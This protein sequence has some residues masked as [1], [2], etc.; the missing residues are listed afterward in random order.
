MYLSQ[1][2]KYIKVV[3]MEANEKSTIKH[4]M[5]TSPCDFELDSTGNLYVVN[6]GNP[7]NVCLF[8]R[9]GNYIKTLF[10]QNQL[11]GIGLNSSGDKLVVTYEQFISVYEL[12]K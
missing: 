12:Q 11:R 4:P 3:D 5:L 7:G 6:S 10:K 9:E 1:C 2:G 8:D